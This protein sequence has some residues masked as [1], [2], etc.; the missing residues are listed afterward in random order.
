MIS[1]TLPYPPT[2]NKMW[3][4]VQGRTLLSADGR[5]YRKA[6]ADECMALGS[7]AMGNERLE[8]LVRVCPPDRRRRD[9]DNVLKGPLDALEKAGVYEDDSQIDR[10]MLER[11]EVVKG[12]K[13]EVVISVIERLRG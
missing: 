4:N 13:L 7:P 6:V 8:V 12:G 3:R 5:K 9:L 1:I 10:L 11:G 2:V